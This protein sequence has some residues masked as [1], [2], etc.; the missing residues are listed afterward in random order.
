MGDNIEYPCCFYCQWH[1]NP[2]CRHPSKLRKTPLAFYCDYFER[3]ED[4]D[5]EEEEEEDSNLEEEE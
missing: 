2:H 4:F 5:Y 1:S 3:A